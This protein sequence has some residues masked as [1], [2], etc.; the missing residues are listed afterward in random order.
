M[1]RQVWT[2]SDKSEPVQ[3]SLYLFRPVWTS[4]DL[5][6]VIIELLEFDADVMTSQESKNHLP[7]LLKE[8]LVVYY[9]SIIWNLLWFRLELL[10]LQWTTVHVDK[11]IMFIFIFS[12]LLQ[13]PT[14]VRPTPPTSPSRAVSNDSW[15]PDLSSLFNRS[16]S[17]NSQGYL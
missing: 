11:L 8:K 14:R 10:I 4:L 3:I 6:G 12:S 17:S 5:F 2:C 15:I 16:A 9:K 1:F 13:T 7:Q